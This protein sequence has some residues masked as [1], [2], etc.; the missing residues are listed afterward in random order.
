MWELVD[1]VWKHAGDRWDSARP[2]AA[3]DFDSTLHLFKK[4]GPA[5]SLTLAFLRAL[6]TAGKWNVVIFTNR[7]SAAEDKLAELRA[8]VE[9]LTSEG[10]SCDVYAATARNRYRKPQTGMWDMFCEDRK[11]GAPRPG[12]YFCGDAA[13]REGDFSASDS[14]FALNIKLKFRVP[15][16]I[17]GEANVARGAL[18]AP[19]P[20][21]P[22]LVLE[23]EIQKALNPARLEAVDRAVE[24][25]AECEIVLMVGS[26]ASG[27]SAFAKRLEREHEFGVASQDEQGSFA[28]CLKHAQALRRGGK[29][30]VIDNTHRSAAARAQYL[31]GMGPATRIAI[32]WFKTPQIMCRHLDGFRCDAGEAPHLLPAIVI[33]SFWKNFEPPDETEG[34]L[35]PL[36]FAFSPEAG[37]QVSNRYAP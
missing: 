15:E 18:D 37:K 9:H 13:G 6:N 23:A 11:V 19:R 4:R 27:K 14:N 29:R 3:F 30:V 35:Y 7:S 1:T 24:A 26:P 21:G 36:E 5:D 8:Y 22:A 25:V 16:E 32:V 17:F 10:V 31:G 12:S 20:A 2:I 28:R 34:K 33:P